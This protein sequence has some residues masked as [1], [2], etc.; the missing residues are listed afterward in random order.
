M[1]AIKIAFLLSAMIIPLGLSAESQA[2]QNQTIKDF[3]LSNYKE[4]G[5]RDWEIKGTEAIVQDKF[6]NIDNMEAKYYSKDD[7]MSIKSDKA[8]LNKDNMN[9]SLKDNIEVTIPTEGGKEYTTITCDGP[10]EM[11]YNEGN[12]V[13]NN[14][15]VVTNQGGKLYCDKA[16]VF[17]DTTAKKMNRIVAEGNVQIVR[18]DNITYAQ[19]ATYYVDTKKV[20]LEGSPR[21][22]YYPKEKKES[23]T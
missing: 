9:A 7:V 14:R 18:E 22:I 13:F 5:S 20:V 12:A 16:Y 21:L 23:S 10:L 1:R 15:V 4:N 8:K 19:K 6:V 3:Y 17:F 2:P 11:E